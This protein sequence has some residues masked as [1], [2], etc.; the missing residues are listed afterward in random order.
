MGG[1]KAM[2][3][4]RNSL[5]FRAMTHS[6]TMTL[7]HMEDPDEHIMIQLI[8]FNAQPQGSASVEQTEDN[9]MT[10]I[11]SLT[12]SNGQSHSHIRLSL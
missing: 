6:V 10:L 5:V 11:R 8:G 9:L 4:K 3:L 12:K 1:F 2:K 7:C